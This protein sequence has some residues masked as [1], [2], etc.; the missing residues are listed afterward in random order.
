MNMYIT[1]PNLSYEINENQTSIISS[2][3][4]LYSKCGDVFSALGAHVD[5]DGLNDSSDLVICGDI[6]NIQSYDN[7]ND[8]FFDEFEYVFA[9]CGQKNGARFGV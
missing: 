7:W 9:N 1:Y 8:I 6:I 3:G 5:P 2:L 4:D